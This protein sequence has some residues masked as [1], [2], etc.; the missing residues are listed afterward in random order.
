MQSCNVCL[1][2]DHT[3]SARWHVAVKDNLTIDYSLEFEHSELALAATRGCPTCTIIRD[4]L[5]LMSRK[6]FLFEDWKPCRGRLILQTDWPLEVE[7]IDGHKQDSQ[8]VRFQ[9]YK[10]E[11]L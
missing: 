11:G 4:G 10:Y 9:Y 5:E 1:D 6:S 8:S 7:V 2:L 3:S